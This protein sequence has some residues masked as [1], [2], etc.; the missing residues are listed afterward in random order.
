MGNSAEEKKEQNMLELAMMTLHKY[1]KRR[2]ELIS[3]TYENLFIIN[4][5]CHLRIKK[6]SSKL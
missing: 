3:A 4:I 5:Q 2:L 1:F 6:V